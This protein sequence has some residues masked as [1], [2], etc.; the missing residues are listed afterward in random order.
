LSPTDFEKLLRYEIVEISSDQEYKLKKL[1]EE[2]GINSSNNDSK[3][4]SLTYSKNMSR[5]SK[6]T[7]K[8]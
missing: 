1:K 7:K 2:L 5:I 6:A 4:Q 3:N 8:K